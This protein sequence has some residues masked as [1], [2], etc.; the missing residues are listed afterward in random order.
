MTTATML[1][2]DN[3][4]SRT[5]IPRN[6]SRELMC[7]Y[8]SEHSKDGSVQEMMLDNNA[9]TL[10][11]LEMPEI[12]NLLPD[13]TEQN[14]LELGAGIGRFTGEIAKKCNHIIACDFMESFIEK[15]R[16]NNAHHNNI[17]YRCVDV[18][19]LD[20]PYNSVDL[21]FTN[22]LF[23]Y[24]DDQELRELLYKMLGWLRPGGALF[25][26]E[27]CFHR[28]GSRS[29]DGI[30]PTQYRHPDDYRNLLETV[31]NDNGLPVSTF[32]FIYQK[33]VQ[34]YVEMKNNPNQICWLARKNQN[35]DEESRGGWF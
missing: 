23:M 8:W 22:W 26:R 3:N 13:Y 14:V 4:G 17:D 12:L 19:K 10:T 25:F 21:I 11:Q 27:S 24:L 7:D 32:Q 35:H 6:Q 29:R 34:T 30:N 2:V 15:N 16:E 5:T 9:E 20:L 28:S 18:T 33:Q 31:K 1:Y